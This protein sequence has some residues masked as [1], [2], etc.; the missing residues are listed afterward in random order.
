MLGSISTNAPPGKN[1]CTLCWA[2]RVGWG[3][4][5]M[6]IGT[7]LVHCVPQ[8]IQIYVVQCCSENGAMLHPPCN[9]AP[10]DIAAILHKC[11]IA[12][13][14]RLATL[15]FCNTAAMLH[16]IALLL[17]HGNQ[18]QYCCILHPTSNISPFNIVPFNIAPCNML[19]QYCSNIARCNTNTTIID[20]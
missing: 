8:P 3:V 4:V 15:Q 11:N 20:T 1:K 18:M 14:L 16:L 17:Q 12:A 2:S 10:C 7:K 6:E 19:L 5:H 9:I 13:M